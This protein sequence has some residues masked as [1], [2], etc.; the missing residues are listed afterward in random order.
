MTQTIDIPSEVKIPP[1]PAQELTSANTA[2][3]F[4]M[5][6]AVT[7]QTTYELAASEVQ[8]LKAR[9]DKLEQARTKLKAPILEAGRQIDALFKP[10]IENLDAAIDTVKGTM[11]TY[12]RDLERKAA[13]ERRRH[14]EEVRRAQAEAMRK[15]AE[16]RAKAEAEARRKREEEERARQAADEAARRAREAREAGDRAAAEAAEKE[17]REAEARERAAREQAAKAAQK[18]DERAHA[19]LAKAAEVAA[20]PAPEAEKATAKGVSTRT[21]W[22]AEVVDL[23]LLVDAVASGKAPITW[24]MANERAL[25]DAAKSLKGD[26]GTFAPGVRAVEKPILASR[27]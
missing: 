18:G 4:A 15:A 8:S 25:N 1:V 7:S 19:A 13:E 3:D 9:R 11:L 23:K 5:Q 14:E 22:S 6:V 10:A 26:L 24:L 12:Q 21:L 17:R 16:E 20:R 27:A 2:L